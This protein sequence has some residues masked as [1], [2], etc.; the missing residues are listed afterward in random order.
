MKKVI[1]LV[2]LAAILCVTLASCGVMLSGEYKTT[3][4]L[5][6][7]SSLKF[8]GNKV[9]RVTSASILG[10]DTQNGTYSIKDNTITFVFTNDNGEKVE[11][12]YEFAQNTEAK[13]IT[14]GGVTYTKQ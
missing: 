4:V 5:G 13:T 8:S 10:K 12:S 7:Y 1:A 11:E 9:T 2:I 6:A 14:V 3:E